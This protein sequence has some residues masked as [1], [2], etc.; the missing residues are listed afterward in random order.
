MVAIG[1][2]V[3][4]CTS[5]HIIESKSFKLYLNS[6]NQTHFENIENVIHTIER[7]LSH[8]V[9]T[10]VRVNLTLLKDIDTLPIGTFSGKCLDALDIETNEYRVNPSFLQTE[11]KTVTEQLY[12][13]LLKSNC[14]VTG[15]PDWGSLQI[16]YTGH[17][18][19]PDGLLKYI[20]SFRQHNE[21]HEQCVERI[22]T[23]IMRQ[24]RPT[25][26]TVEARYTRRGGLDINPL[27]T[28]EKDLFLNNIRH[29]RQ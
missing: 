15:Q 8:C 13:D 16:G 26:L 24:C 25:Q 1:T 6:F 22:F 11:P 17:K 12:S 19:K 20:I 29:W 21:F 2:F 27:R 7:D 10:S 23:D 28:T 14:P 5:P 9:D 4:P 18:I 3:I